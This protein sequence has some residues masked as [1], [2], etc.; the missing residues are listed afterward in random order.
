MKEWPVECG[1]ISV[2]PLLLLLLFVQLALLYIAVE[3]EGSVVIGGSSVISGSVVYLVQLSSMASCNLFNC[4]QWLSCSWGFS[5]CEYLSCCQMLSGSTCSQ[6]LRSYRQLGE[7]ST[8][9]KKPTNC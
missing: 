9:R 6:K 5:C 2:C 4:C 3:L 8:V 7:C 1:I